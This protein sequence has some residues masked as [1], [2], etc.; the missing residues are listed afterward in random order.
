MGDC[1]TIIFHQSVVLLSFQVIVSAPPVTYPFPQTPPSNEGCQS[2]GCK[3]NLKKQYSFILQDV[4]S[5]FIYISS[6]SFTEREVWR[7]FDPIFVSEALFAFAN[8]LSFSRLSYILPINEFLGPLQ[9]SLGRMIGDIVR[10]GAVFFVVFL[11]FFCSFLNLYWSL[12]EES[13]F[14]T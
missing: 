6:L 9:I 11:A 5:I 7:S 4:Y 14:G 10:F 12:G 3:Y 8:V 1:S 13:N 2:R